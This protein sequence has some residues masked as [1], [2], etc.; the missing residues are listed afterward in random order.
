MRFKQELH[1]KWN[2]MP[3]KNIKYSS[4]ITQQFSFQTSYCKQSQNLKSKEKQKR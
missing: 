1:K 3:L 4:L 2:Y